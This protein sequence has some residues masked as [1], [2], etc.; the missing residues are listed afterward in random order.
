MISQAE[1][2][3]RHRLPTRKVPR[4][5]SRLLG[6]AECD[7]MDMLVPAYWLLCHRQDTPPVRQ[8]I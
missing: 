2:L 8:Q 7:D 6:I 4:L 3:P 1:L 5:P